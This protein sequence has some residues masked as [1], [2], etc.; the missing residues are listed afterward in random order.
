MAERRPS[1]DPYGI[2]QALERHRVKYVLIGGFARVLRG[3][4]ELTRGVDIVP[5]P[6]SDNL[7]RL[8]DA[9]QE[10]AARRADG[11][12]LD[13]FETVT[14][15]PPL[16]ELV[17]EHGE[18]KIVPT[19]AGTRG[20]DD[21]RRGAHREPLGQGVRSDV[22]SIGDLARMSST[23]GSERHLELVRQ[24]RRLTALE[25]GRGRVIER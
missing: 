9:L 21:L 14:I 3:T 4:E 25:R 17:T 7:R 6:R 11:Q 12:E 10:I 23:L 22:A 2:L 15:E 5:A 8:D 24:L 18:L 13:R 16:I 19:P 20:Y 1:F